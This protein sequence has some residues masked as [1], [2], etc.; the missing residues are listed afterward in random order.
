M[1]VCTCVD[2]KGLLFKEA[3]L[4]LKRRSFFKGRDLLTIKGGDLITIKRAGLR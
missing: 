2:G 3:G 4:R 1:C